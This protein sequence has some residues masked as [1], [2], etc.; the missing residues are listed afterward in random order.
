MARM[1]IGNYVVE[2]DAKNWTVSEVRTVQDAESPNYGNEYE[3]ALGYYGKLSGALAALPE[4]FARSSDA[5]DLRT[6]L[7]EMRAFQADIQRMLDT[8]QRAA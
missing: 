3:V 2:S 8:P 5:S 7:A 4:F 1:R 6:L